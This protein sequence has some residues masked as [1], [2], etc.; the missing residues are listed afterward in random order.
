L[1]HWS[2]AEQLIGLAAVHFWLTQVELPLQA[3][4]SLHAVPSDCPVHC[5]HGIVIFAVRQ[6]PGMKQWPSLPLKK[7]SLLAA[8]L[9]LNDQRANGNRKVAWPLA[10]VFLLAAVIPSTE[11]GVTALPDTAAPVPSTTVTT[12]AWLTLIDAD[13]QPG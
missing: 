5:P 11:V 4:A 7:N 10:F 6:P 13:V 1:W 2:D 3:V 8:H 9:A 12:V